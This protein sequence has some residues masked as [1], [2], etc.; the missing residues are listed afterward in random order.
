MPKTDLSY[1]AIGVLASFALTATL[2]LTAAPTPVAASE[3]QAAP[4]A[5]GSEQE[6]VCRDVSRPGSHIAKRVCGTQAQVV[7]GV[8]RYKEALWTDPLV[9][10]PGVCFRVRDGKWREPCSRTAAAF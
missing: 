3:R 10:P 5:Q 1:G 7:A 9:S 2:A 8:H 6:R 4:S